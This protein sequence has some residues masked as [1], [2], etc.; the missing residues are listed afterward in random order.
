MSQQAS[1]ARKISLPLL[2]LYG[3][4]TILGAGIYVLIGEVALRAQHFAPWSFVVA[5]ILA[6]LTAYSFAKLSAKFP[7]SAGQATYIDAAFH[8]KLLTRLIGYSVIAIGS[9]SAATMLRGFSGYFSVLFAVPDWLT[10]IVVALG[11]TLLA[12]WGITE[13]LSA[14]AL[15]TLI[16]V[17]GL[18]IV[19][20][21]AI[22]PNDIHSINVDKSTF[23]LGGILSG[24]FIA[25]YAYLGFEDIVNVAEET[26]QPKRTLPYAIFISLLLAIS[27]YMLVAYVCVTYAPLEIFAGAKAPLAEIV[28]FRGID[29]TTITLIST[30]AILNGAL[31]QLIM[32]SRVLYGMARQGHAP[33]IFSQ[34]SIKTRTPIASSIM[35]AS[36]IL[37]L[38]SSL[39]LVTLAAITSGITLLI[40]SAMHLALLKMRDRFEPRSRLNLWVPLL[41]IFSNL[42]LLIY[43]LL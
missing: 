10:I 27:L 19:V 37:L 40:F 31:I 17:V 4:G 12:I 9:I 33:I 7:K 35:I 32:A 24:A 34:V 26:I 16:E 38:A 20:F 8:N 29:P 41:G 1:L 28:A 5:G 14:A 42:G 18:A 22:E 23:H 36:I 3:L 25:F 21:V 6:S 43:A 39:P 2:A 13:A 30:I 15:I 11:I